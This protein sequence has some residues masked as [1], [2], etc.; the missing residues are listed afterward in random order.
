LLLTFLYKIGQHSA[1]ISRA[2]ACS[3]SQKSLPSE[4]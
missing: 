4:I 1:Q 3:W 2:S